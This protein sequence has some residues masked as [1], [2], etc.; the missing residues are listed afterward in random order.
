MTLDRLSLLGLRVDCIVGVGPTERNTPQPLGLDLTLHFDSRT[1]AKESRL[2]DTVDYTRIWGE[3]RFLL[4]ASRFLLL[5]SAAAAIAHYLLA[6][7]TADWPHATIEEV[8][9]RLSKPLA[10]AGAGL[11]ALD[12]VRNKKDVAILC[13]PQ[14]FGFK[15]TI[16]ETRETSICR[17]RILPGQVANVPARLGFVESELVIGEGLRLQ[18][19]R[20]T[21]GFARRWRQGQVHGYENPTASELSLLYIARQPFVS[22]DETSLNEALLDVM[23]FF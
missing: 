3:I 4:Q 22:E 21:P 2:Q 8:S 15:D 20:V 18:G 13:E 12:I 10:L 23:R 7:A 17:W 16:F 1:A 14:S 19:E 9:V 6:P 11:P 5:E